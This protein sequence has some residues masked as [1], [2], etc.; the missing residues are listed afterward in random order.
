[1]SSPGRRTRRTDRQ[2]QQSRSKRQ[3]RGQRSGNGP[4]PQRAPK[5]AQKKS[6][7][8]SSLNPMPAR[9]YRAGRTKGMIEWAEAVLRWREQQQKGED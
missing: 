3:G 2:K 9:N 8:V 6:T 7:V 4:R 5:T 1:M